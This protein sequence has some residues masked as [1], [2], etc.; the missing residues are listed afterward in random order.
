MIIG[1]TG[2]IASGKTTVLKNF[3]ELGYKTLDCDR[4]A[5]QVVLPKTPALKK[6]IKT[7]GKKFLKK[8]GS[9]NR[10]KLG[11]LIFKNPKKRKLLEN[12]IHPKIIE[13]LKK[14]I[15]THSSGFLIIDI[16]LLFEKKLQNLVDKTIVVW[17]P[18]KLQ[19]QRLIQRSGISQTQANLRINSQWP[20]SK[21]KKL[22]N[23]FIDNSRTILDTKK[24]AKKCLTK[25]S[26]LVK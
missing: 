23:F 19:A 4:L 20:L 12:I 25:I 6:I 2:G 5:R 22:A 11:V 3:K 14:K 1:L 8:N 26:Q 21:K 18:K 13:I 10:S 9:L 24:Q 15:Q 17:I 16:P 7:F